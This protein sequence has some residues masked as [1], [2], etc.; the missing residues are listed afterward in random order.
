MDAQLLEFSLPPRLL[1]RGFWLYA[2]NILGPK[3][4]RLCY[5]G[6]TGDVTGVAQSPFVR[7]HQHLG[8]KNLGNALRRCLRK[9][10]IDPEDCKELIFSAYGPIDDYTPAPAAN[11]KDTWRKVGALERALWDA[12][13]RDGFELV[14]NR[15][16]SRAD[17][18][19]ALS[20]KIR[21]AFMENFPARSPPPQSD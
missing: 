10:G 4:E 21:S 5:V 7:A 14:N 19:A 2:W 18:D 13:E 20:E 1:H 6:M 11:Y 17:Y 8:E 3:N 15:P 9:R 12:L 16:A